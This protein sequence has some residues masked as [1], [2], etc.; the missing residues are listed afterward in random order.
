M[1]TRRAS[2]TLVSPGAAVVQ[3]K[4]NTRPLRRIVKPFRRHLIIHGLTP[5]GDPASIRLDHLLSLI[6]TDTE[7]GALRSFWLNAEQQLHSD[8]RFFYDLTS[9]TYTRV[10]VYNVYRANVV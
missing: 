1:C 4:N 2:R 9:W 10:R 7:R 6:Y 5:S 8:L 3:I